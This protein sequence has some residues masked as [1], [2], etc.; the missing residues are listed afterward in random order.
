MRDVTKRP[1]IMPKR[2]IKRYLR[3]ARTL[4]FAV[5]I[6]WV[7]KTFAF[8]T[9]DGAPS[10]ARTHQSPSALQTPAQNATSPLRVVLDPGHG[11]NDVGTEGVSGRYEKDLVLNIAL[12]TREALIAQS[13]NAGI[14]LDVW[15]TRDND[16][17]ISDLHHERAKMVY[18]HGG[19]VLISIHANSF[20]DPRV[21]GIETYYDDPR[22]SLTLAQIM[23]RALVQATGFNDRGVRRADFYMLKET[24][25]PAVLLEVGYMTNEAEEKKLWDERV[26]KNIAQ[27]I[28]EGVLEYFMLDHDQGGDALSP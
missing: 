1:S 27:A 14:H 28:A 19:D 2:K 8:T 21:S 11:G 3:L 15:M 9:R 26:Q 23:Q 5:L 20:T 22:Q 13:K 10:D 16:R 17:F 4:L 12:L 24:G 25:M 7:F 6:I 18:E